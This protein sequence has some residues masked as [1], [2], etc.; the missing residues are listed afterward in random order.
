MERQH[1]QKA[2]LSPWVKQSGSNL[3][4]NSMIT[5]RAGVGEPGTPTNLAECPG[6][7]RKTCNENNV[8]R[9]CLKL[10]EGK[11]PLVWGMELGADGKEIITNDYWQITDKKSYK[12]EWWSELTGNGGDSRCVGVDSTTLLI[13]K[14]GC[15]A[16]TIRC[17]ATDKA[18]VALTDQPRTPGLKS[19]A[20]VKECFEK[21]CGPLAASISLGDADVQPGGMIR[22]LGITTAGCAAVAAAAMM[23]RRRT[24]PTQDEL[25]G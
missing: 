6:S 8:H 1:A 17:D 14:V 13:N 10:L 3:R 16:V 21:Q 18:F 20:P 19:L 5:P 11:S 22:L 24:P 25:L 15:D 12:F 2:A 4:F 9:V 23:L 7:R